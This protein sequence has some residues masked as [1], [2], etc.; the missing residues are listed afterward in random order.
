MKPYLTDNLCLLSPQKVLI[1]N[2]KDYTMFHYKNQK[3]DN[4]SSYS[5]LTRDN[6]LV[7]MCCILYPMHYQTCFFL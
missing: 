6:Y 3:R 1:S 2:M 7:L 4:R 5:M